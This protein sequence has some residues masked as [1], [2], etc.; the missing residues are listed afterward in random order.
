MDTEEKVN[1]RVEFWLG[2]YG[3]PKENIEVCARQLRQGFGA[4]RYMEGVAAGGAAV[5]EILRDL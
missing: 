1:D 3:M 2:Y 5:K 4:S